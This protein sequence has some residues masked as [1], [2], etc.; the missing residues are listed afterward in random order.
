MVDCP[1]PQVAGRL[2]VGYGTSREIE[3]KE[4]LWRM[5]NSGM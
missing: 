3:A 2:R 4:S 5:W 1:I